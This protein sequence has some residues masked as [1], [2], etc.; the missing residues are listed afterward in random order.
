MRLVIVTPFLETRGGLDR[1]ILKIAQHFD[2]K[3]HC[4][5]YNPEMTFP[6]FK[7]MDIEVSK[8][9]LVGRVPV[10]GRVTSAI[11]AGNHFY[12]L[13]L[14][15]YDVIN[16]HQTPSEW[17]RHKNKNV[18]WYCH[19]PNREAFDLYDWRMKRRGILSKPAFWASIQA[20]KQLEFRTVPNIEYIFT[21]SMNSQARIK[22]YLKRESE[23]LYPAVEAEK[24]R[25]RMYEDFFFY[26]S[27]IAPEKD[28]E[29][30]I[31]AFKL[32]SNRVKGYKMIIA[33][34]LS[35]RKDHR[36]YL[37]K[38]RAMGGA[39][40]IVETNVTDERLLDLYSR[41]KAVLYSPINEDYG[42]VPLE[43]MASSKPCIAKNEGGPKETII[44]GK[45]G[46]LVPSMWK[47]ADAMEYLA[48]HP[49]KCEE[50]G[51][52]GRNKVLANFTWEK[53]LKRFEEKA[54]EI[55]ASS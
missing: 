52:E 38:I 17:I 9:G 39:N 48:K 32:F 19:T 51:K 23:V 35:D 3:L 14:G 50:M 34:S 10:L 8:P 46:F 4:I 2:A 55:S 27:R 28:F 43:A 16:A 15:D 24:F 49:D 7:G 5:R 53:F 12:N 21:N 44:H 33:G 47:M 41:C 40:V 18:V 1:V 13:K 6:E 54:R 22:R 26:P 30:A 45:D 20:F 37:K 36:D 42:L 25:C 31:E 11:D 29:Y